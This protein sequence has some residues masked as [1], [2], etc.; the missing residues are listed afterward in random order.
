MTYI[1]VGNELL[2]AFYAGKRA[3]NATFRDAETAPPAK[4]RP[5]GDA[6]GYT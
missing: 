2:Q 5:A 4:G 1:S 3:I 6:T